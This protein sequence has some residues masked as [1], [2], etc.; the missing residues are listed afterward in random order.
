M[1]AAALAALA[2]AIAVSAQPAHV[3]DAPWPPLA[4][5]AAHTDAEP[6]SAA[7]DPW[8]WL[9]PL[10]A[11]HAQN[12]GKCVTP[13]GGNNPSIS[14][15]RFTSPNGTYYIDDVIGIRVTGDSGFSETVGVS[16][17][18]PNTRIQLE[19]GTVDRFAVYDS[20]S[21]AGGYA[22]YTYTVNRGDISRDLDYLESDSLHW[23]WGGFNAN[24]Q[25]AGEDNYDCTLPDPG[26][27]GSL[28]A[29]GDIVV[30]GSRA[31]P[32][33]VQGVTSDARN[34]TYPL[35]YSIA[36]TVSFDGAVE[37]SGEEPFLVIGLDGGVNRTVPYARGNGT[38][39]L[40]FNYTVRAG[41]MSADLDYNGTGSLGGNITYGGGHAVDTALPRPGSPGSLGHSKDIAVDGSVPTVVR[42]SSP[43][44]TG[45]H[46]AGDAII[47]NVTFSEA[48]SA[49]TTQGR[50]SLALDT[51][52]AASYASGSGTASLLFSYAVAPGDM[53]SGLDYANASAL[54]LNG[55]T[56]EDAAGNPANLELPAPSGSRS[57]AG[58]SALSVDG[59]RPRVENVSSP[60]ATGSYGAGDT[61]IVNVTFSE[62]VSANTTQGLPSLLLETGA[63]DRAAAYASGSGTAS[64]VFEYAVMSGDESDD[65]DYAGES[66]LSL[67]GG[68]VEDAAGNPANLD[69]PAPSGSRSLAGTSGIAVRAGGDGGTDPTQPPGGGNGGDGGGDG[70]GTDPT[71]PPGGGNGGGGGTDPTQPPGGGNGGDG[72][73]G[74]GGT[75][76]TQPPGGGNGGDGGTDPTQP[77]GGF[78]LAGH[79]GDPFPVPLQGPSGLAEGSNGTI[80]VADTLGG[81]VEVFHENGTHAMK[82]GKKGYIEIERLYSPAVQRAIFADLEGRGYVGAG[83]PGA[84][85]VEDRL[86]LLRH[87]HGLHAVDGT[88]YVAD[89]RNLR[90]QA[91]NE[92][93]GNATRAYPIWSTVFDVAVRPDGGVMAAADPPRNRV[94]LINMSTG[95]PA[96]PPIGR[97]C[98]PFE[99]RRG[100]GGGEFSRPVSVAFAGNGT[101]YVG[102]SGNGRVQAFSP[103]GD[104]ASSI[105]MPPHPAAANASAGGAAPAAPTYV[106]VDDSSGTILVSAS[107][108]DTV[109]ELAVSN[110]SVVRTFG[111]PAVL[112]GP[113]GVLL[114]SNGRVYVADSGGDRIVAFE[115]DG[116]QAGTIGF[117][118]HGPLEFGQLF[119]L[120][121]E[122]DGRIAAADSGNDRVQLAVR[123]ANGSYVH[124]GSFGGRGTGDGEMREP[125][126]I[127]TGPNGDIFVADH[128]NGRVQRF[129]GNGA[130][131][132][133]FPVAGPGGAALAPL[134]L[135]VGPDGSVHVASFGDDSIHRFAQDGRLLQTMGAAL[136]L[137]VPINLGIGPDGRIYAV[138]EGGARVRVLSPDG[139]PLFDVGRPP[140]LGEFY[141]NGSL[142]GP[143]DVEVDRNGRIIVVD[144]GHDRLQVFDHAGGFVSS[145]GS[146][147]F[148]PHPD[149]SGSGVQFDRPA[150]LA[151][152]ADGATV[153]VADSLNHRI[154]I[155]EPNDAEA[156]SIVLAAAPSTDPG[157]APAGVNVTI[158]FDEPMRVYQRPGSDPP[159][160]L[161]SVGG[162]PAVEAPYAS[163]AGTE[164]LVF[165]HEPAGGVAAGA[166]PAAYADGAAFSLNNGSITDLAGN[167]ADL[168]LGVGPGGP[169]EP[170]CGGG[171]VTCITV[172]ELRLAGADAPG[173][174]IGGEVY[175]A[176]ALAAADWNGEREAEGSPLRLRLE[177]VDLASDSPADGVAA[178][179]GRGI[180]AYL[181]P[182]SSSAAAALGPLAA[183]PDAVMVS[184]TSQAVSRPEHARPDGL[185]RLS[186]N[187]HYEADLLV[188]AAH[189]GGVTT[190]IPV[191]AAAYGADYEEEMRR[192]AG[193][194]GMDVLDAVRM[195]GPGRDP[196]AAAAE[197]NASVAA[198]LAMPGVAGPSE[199]GLLVAS[200]AEDLRSVAPHA[201]GYPLL[202]SVKWFEPG[203]LLPPG[204]IGDNGTLG[205][206]RAGLLHSVSWDVP[207]TALLDRVRGALAAAGGSGGAWP[208]QYAYSAYDAVHVLADAVALSAD[209]AGGHT[210]AGVAARM[211][212]AAEGLGGLLGGDLRLDGNGDRISPNRVVI[213]RTEAGTG[214]WA[215]TGVRAS[216][217]HVCGI[218]LASPKIAFGRVGTGGMSGVAEQEIVNAGTL[219]LASV[220]ISAAPWTDAAGDAVLPA[221]ATSV[222]VGGA[223]WEPLDGEVAAPPEGGERAAAKFRLDVPP[224]ALPPDTSVAVSQDVTYTAMC[225]PPAG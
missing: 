68:T 17:G 153:Y 137:D 119:D 80:V 126:G 63:T 92:T 205:L 87:P 90:V 22:D 188:I 105:R 150:G 32:P 71:Q 112:D 58:M 213:W 206:A 49:N 9:E 108:A 94:V 62:A 12:A 168:S 171:S 132:S 2:L 130:Y 50:P 114:H 67:N 174:R 110:G 157:P 217:D 173:P 100:S 5:R 52:G 208:S 59:V 175:A 79:I 151:V 69:L 20:H 123:A 122:R 191:V 11:A 209:A 57:L 13:T 88:I 104:Y 139:S 15:I 199:V 204:P 43:N 28:A 93:T 86:G 29:Q 23:K 220:S 10:P 44:T 131:V 18:L 165:R 158:V 155:L 14:S 212:E 177:R 70:G 31:R 170:R 24:I 186:I 78:T 102:D 127:D 65:L 51:G 77:P 116:A 149:C 41:D 183:A 152:G 143:S 38:S 210:A 178:A 159:S 117:P 144:T 115:R 164:T 55:G 185:F 215:D 181:G 211:H 42:V 33:A 83:N 98:N 163:G 6:P 3:G 133:Q 201:A 61:I 25:S 136:G 47:V 224:G 162:G 167:R 91:F 192:A 74:D 218:A 189:R 214:A 140:T 4:E 97:D 219:P 203:R 36:V 166:G 129:D 169:A 60:N 222:M 101:M 125:R 82:I 182:T 56:V 221:G 30:D 184:P 193:L 172:G 146:F 135:A 84:L 95:L 216:L 142:L 195:P 53:S 134:G 103:G 197:I 26:T 118:G 200:S 141:G 54:S 148:C 45:P 16:T 196:S 176:Y 75:D 161:I 99:C 7:G 21:R 124:A 138:E 27:A 1:A 19:T 223:E 180:V 64:L 179:L 128:E 76:P 121:V 198:A 34:G 89:T 154:V 202:S 194:L 106:A 37:Y 109:Y 111:G 40:V 113:E 145:T 107:A 187:D 156:P 190:A 225:E 35:N 39:G 46:G 147:G 8:Q 207:E 72:G 48:V 81:H 66:A 120:A 160:A 96:E 85:L 73:G